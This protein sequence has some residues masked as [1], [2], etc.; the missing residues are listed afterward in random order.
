M[1]SGP[2][3]FRFMIRV[4]VL[5]NFYIVSVVLSMCVA[6]TSGRFSGAGLFKSSSNAVATGP[7]A[8]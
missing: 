7:V 1:L 4:M 3:T 5:L 8:H 6:S 2:T